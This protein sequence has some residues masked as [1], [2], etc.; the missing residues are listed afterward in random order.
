MTDDERRMVVAQLTD[1]IQVKV[2]VVAKDRAG[3]LLLGVPDRADVDTIYTDIQSHFWRTRNTAKLRPR[4]RELIL[5]QHAADYRGGTKQPLAD[6]LQAYVEE[7]RSAG[8]PELSILELGCAN[9]LTLRHL[10]LIDPEMPVRFFGMEMTAFL[11]DELLAQFPS[12]TAVAGGA[13]EFLTMSEDD[14]GAGRF[15]VFLVSGVLCQMPPDLAGRVLKHAA[16]FCDQVLMWDYLANF[17][18]ELSADEPIIFLLSPETPHLLFVNPYAR[19]LAEAGFDA[20]E[21]RLSESGVQTD[22][23]GAVRAR[24]TAI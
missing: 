8:T 19:L 1:R 10:K 9:G 6:Y 2:H 12:A 11:A 14:F 22:G 3:R 16:R 23:E 18:G 5:G 15:D 13:D 20:V 24:K 17:D 7:A 4:D 21:R